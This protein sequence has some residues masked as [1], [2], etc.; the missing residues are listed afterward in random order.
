MLGSVAVHTLVLMRG[1][2]AA[3]Q[4][5]RVEYDSGEHELEIGDEVLVAN[6]WWR[7]AD[8]QVFPVGHEPEHPTFWC[9]PAQPVVLHTGRYEAPVY[10]EELRPVLGVVR[11][12]ESDPARQLA[13]QLD[14]FV[15]R[16]TDTIHLDDGALGE[17]QSALHGLS[18][19][20]G[21]L[22][23]NLNNLR[24]QVHRHLDDQRQANEG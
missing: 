13:D 14:A 19:E 16:Q 24:T 23:P 2:G 21:G 18:I 12:F 17:L 15:N 4:R 7:L 11:R 9:E 20:R 6:S 22:T 1:P 5:E 10:R 8:V 3:V